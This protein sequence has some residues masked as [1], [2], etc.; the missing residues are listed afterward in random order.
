MPETSYHGAIR[1]HV[2]A[3]RDHVEMLRQPQ[4]TW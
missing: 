4:M 3:I 2:D 1:D